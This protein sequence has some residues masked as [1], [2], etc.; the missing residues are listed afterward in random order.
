LHVDGGFDVDGV[1]QQRI[2][3]GGMEL[4]KLVVPTMDGPF[5]PPKRTIDL[6]FMVVLR[7][8]VTDQV[9]R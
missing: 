7:F 2:D 6:K 4:V 8:G 3:V 9:A 1:R 5:P